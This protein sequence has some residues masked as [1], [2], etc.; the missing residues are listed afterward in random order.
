MQLPKYGCL[1]LICAFENNL[2]KTLMH[3]V[4]YCF[5]LDRHLNWS[6]NTCVWR[7]FGS[8]NNLFFGWQKCWFIAIVLHAPICVCL[9]CFVKRSLC[10]FQFLTQG[11]VLWFST[12]ACPSRFWRLSLTLYTSM[13]L[14]LI[15]QVSMLSN[16][17]SPSHSRAIQA[18]RKP[19]DPEG[20]TSLHK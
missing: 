12:W 2:L 19:S 4:R 15:W 5:W 7:P 20:V 1:V 17:R 9:D 14:Q 6:W 8:F 13:S 18:K 10:F 3:C 11:H 16:V